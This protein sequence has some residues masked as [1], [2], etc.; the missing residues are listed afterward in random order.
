VLI[1]AARKSKGD[2]HLRPVLR[3]VVPEFR[4]EA[5]GGQS[6]DPASNGTEARIG[7]DAGDQSRLSQDR[8]V[9]YD[10]RSGIG[11][12]RRL[13]RSRRHDRRRG[14][15]RRCGIDRRMGLS[16]ELYPQAAAV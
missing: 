6:P 2:E 5:N 11:N 15:D 4:P 8:R 14:R 16:A 13:A 10:R 9:G 3:W 12:R 7:Q 1:D